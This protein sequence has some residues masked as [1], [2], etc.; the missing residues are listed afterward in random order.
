LKQLT[1][2]PS[3]R[4][5]EDAV[6]A[7][8]N[9]SF[10]HVHCGFH[11]AAAALPVFAVCKRHGIAVIADEGTLHGC[12]DEAFVG[13]PCPSHFQKDPPVPS[14]PAVLA[15]VQQMGGWD[16]VQAALVTVK[17]IADKHGVTMQSVVLRWQMD[18]GATPVVLVPWSHP[19][20]C[21]GKG[22][23]E[24]GP[25]ADAKLFQRHSFLDD[26]DMDNLNALCV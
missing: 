10:A 3:C 12:V 2:T 16:L 23:L 8:V 9:I 5:I 20:A 18:L 21:V 11:N 25:P 19:G 13:I 1:Q 7:G 24:A 22:P 6:R 15:M 26:S 14:V 4:A 17:K